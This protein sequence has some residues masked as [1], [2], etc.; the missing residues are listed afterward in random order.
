MPRQTV[1]VEAGF[2]VATTIATS[3]GVRAGSLP[4]CRAVQALHVGSYESIGA[5]YEAVTDR[6]RQEG[7]TE[8]EDMWEC[9][10]SEPSD[11]PSTQR[12]LIVWP[13]S[14]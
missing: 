8:S 9:Y 11:D 14:N 10:L 3:D 5:T 1:D 2:P 6:I 4:A 13:V 12:T 7:L